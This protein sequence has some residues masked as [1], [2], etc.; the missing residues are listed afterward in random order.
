MKNLEISNVGRPD[1]DE[2][3]VSL[4]ISS[5]YFFLTGATSDWI[6][7]GE[8]SAFPIQA[9]AAD[10][11]PL[12]GECW[13][14]QS[15]GADKM[16]LLLISAG[17]PP[18]EWIVEPR[19]L[20]FGNVSL[21]NSKDLSLTL[22]NTGTVPLYV[23]NMIFRSDTSFSASETLKGDY[24]PGDSKTIYITFSPT[25]AGYHS[26]TIDLYTD[27]EPEYFGVIMT[28]IGTVGIFTRR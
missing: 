7:G 4:A 8:S 23:Q 15:T 12:K 20:E 21:G 28:G 18:G 5:A 19:E 2:L 3:F 17:L 26:G 11:G 10:P 22:R 1:G 9:Y 27:G 13:V 16:V 24:K 25:L 14:S 6:P